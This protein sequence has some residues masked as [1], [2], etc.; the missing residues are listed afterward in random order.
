MLK[1]I[2]AKISKRME[3]LRFPLIVLIVF[4]HNYAS[5][6]RLQQGVEAGVKFNGF[7]VDFTRFLISQGVAKVAV[8]LFFIMS[9][10]LFFSGEWSSATY[11]DKLKRRL[12]TLLVPY[13]FWNLLSLTCFALAPT[14]PQLHV[15]F[16]GVRWPPMHSFAGCVNGLFQLS[17]LYIIN[18]ISYQFWFIRNLMG[19]VIL[20]PAIYFLL[21]RRSALPFIA[22]LFCWWFFSQG[23]ILWRFVESALFFSLG[24]YFSLAHRNV[25]YLDRFGPWIGA[26]FACFLIFRSAFPSLPFLHKFVLVCG[27]PSLWWLTKLAAETVVLKSWCVRLSSASFFVYVAHEP[28]LTLTRKPAYRLLSPTSGAAILTLYFLIPIF[29]ITLLVAT[30]RGL[31]Q[32][33]PSFLAFITGS[34]YRLNTYTNQHPSI[35]DLPP[36]SQQFSFKLFIQPSRKR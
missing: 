28:L 17:I 23:D 11:G 19:L 30:Y 7:W 22:I 4:N 18:P 14:I 29:L 3:I 13:L 24:A 32:T 34:A 5:T 16:S 6:V 10:Y 2:D 26:A 35:L 31:R 20:A 33:M 25:N 15:L 27:V 21:T 8:P 12:R 1:L 36:R 9:G